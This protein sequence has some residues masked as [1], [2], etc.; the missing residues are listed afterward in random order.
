MSGSGG[1]V[2]GPER[3]QVDSDHWSAPRPAPA[4]ALAALP[5]AV[6]PLAAGVLVGAW[7]ACFRSYGIFDFADEGAQLMQALRAA[8]GERPYVDFATGYGPL[9]F[10]IQG[11]LVSAGGL[12]AV[13]LALVAVHAAA[14]AM[15]YAAA[16][17]LVGSAGAA[18]TVLVSVAFFLPRAPRQGAPFLVPYP[19]W[20]VEAI[21]LACMLLVDRRHGRPGL[22]RTAAVGAL[23][24][25]ACV[26]KPNSGLLL[27][28]GGVAALVLDP[29]PAAGRSTGHAGP[30]GTAL[31]L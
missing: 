3:S 25:A 21:A 4:T 2:G 13:R 8:H 12:D 14:A 31:L 27:A 7:I 28:A 6:G 18:V 5:A 24:G 16:R 26:M 29:R 11:A 17:R 9:H 1:S 20:W 22:A 19:A 30:L 15:L 10:A 23:A